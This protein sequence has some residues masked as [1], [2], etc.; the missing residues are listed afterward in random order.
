MEILD[1]SGGFKSLCFAIEAGSIEALDAWIS[2]LCCLKSDM[3]SSLCKLNVQ[4]AG[5]WFCLICYALIVSYFI[6][7]IM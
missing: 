6:S 7:A 5:R 4:N 1:F 2:A 3:N